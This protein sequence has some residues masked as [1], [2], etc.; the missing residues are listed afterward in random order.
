MVEQLLGADDDWQ[1]PVAGYLYPKLHQYLVWLGGLIGVPLYAIGGVGSTQYVG[2][3]DIDEETLEHEFA[4]LGLL[5]N[6]IT[7]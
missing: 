6:P 5:R 3:V 1:E 4:D 7:A 2:T